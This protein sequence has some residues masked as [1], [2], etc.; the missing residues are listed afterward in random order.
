M[1]GPKAR[2]ACALDIRCA[3]IHEKHHIRGSP[4]L[5]YYFVEEATIR[6]RESD[7]AR[8]EAVVEPFL[9]PECT[10]HVV[11]TKWILIRA[12][13][14]SEPCLAD[15][16]HE[17]QGPRIDLDGEPD[18]LKH[19]IDVS[20]H[21]VVT[22][23]GGEHR[24]IVSDAGQRRLLVPPREVQELAG[25]VAQIRFHRRVPSARD[26]LHDAIRVEEDVFDCSGSHA[27]NLSRRRNLHRPRTE[28]GENG[29]MDWQSTSEDTVPSARVSEADARLLRARPPVTGAWRDGD[30]SGHR[31]FAASGP[32]QTESGAELPSIRVAYETWGELSAAHDNAILVLHALTGDSHLRGE[33]G[34]GHPTAGWWEEIIGPGAAIDTDRWFVIAP[35]M[36]GGCQ[37]STGPASVAPDGYE[38]ASRFP[39]SHGS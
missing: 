39:L 13:V 29:C 6:L 2:S 12:E 3:V 35:N 26:L 11:G 25:A 31:K 4:D 16:L 1:H 27:P 20:F 28:P 17:G 34:A 33:G 8:I 32:F 15:A 18:G 38:W 7:I 22:Q 19:L 37:G 21:A 9:V 23:V 5:S 14:N 10:A 30:P 24:T 36:L